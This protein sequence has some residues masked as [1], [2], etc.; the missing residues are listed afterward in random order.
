MRRSAETKRGPSGS[1][2]SRWAKEATDRIESLESRVKIHDL[3]LVEIAVILENMAK[4]LVELEAV[5]LPQRENQTCTWEN[6]HHAHA[7]GLGLRLYCPGVKAP[8]SETVP[9]GLPIRPCWS[10]A[11]MGHSQHV[12]VDSRFMCVCEKRQNS[13]PG[14]P[15]SPDCGRVQTTYVCP[16]HTRDYT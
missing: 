6:P 12:W 10:G 14:T 4:R 5:A 2:V 15:H 7:W 8:E 11:S 1:P 9:E 3:H 16:G 13:D